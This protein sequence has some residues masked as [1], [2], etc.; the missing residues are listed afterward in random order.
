MLNVKIQKEAE[1]SAQW[2]KDNRLCVAGDKTKLL[3]LGT[4]QMKA[5]KALNEDMK[6]VVDGKEVI[7]SSSEKLLGLIINNKITWKNHL[8]GDENNMGLVPQLSK[9][10]GMLKRLSRY[11]SKEKL[12]YF[13]SGIFY[14]KL[15]Y[16]LPVFGN[17]F[18][19]DKYKEENRTYFSITIKD[20]NNLQVHKQTEQ[21]TRC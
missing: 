14:S 6:I 2:L 9:R 7:E 17:I 12:K 15:N 3:I 11:M 16:C 21:T 5:A 19:L 10:L 18:G 20:N 1:N 4:A 13:S 8:Y